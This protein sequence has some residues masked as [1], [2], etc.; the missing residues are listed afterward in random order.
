LPSSPSAARAAIRPVL[1]QW[2]VQAQ[3]D[4]VEL[5]LSEL[6]TNAVR[7]AAGPAPAPRFDPDSVDDVDLESLELALLDNATVGGAGA[8]GPGPRQ[9]EVVAR[10]GDGTLWIEV[11][12][13][14]VRMP[15]V[16]NATA[17]DEGG[18]G[19]F[20]V[21]QLSRRWGARDTPT[22]KA[23]WFQV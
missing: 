7:H 16:R 19:L 20:L 17:N 23:V 14:D 3:A 12:D 22:G 1:E 11:Y 9:V 15:R 8:K 18:R 10:R 6:V 13:Q 2:G 21:D 4:T 5:L